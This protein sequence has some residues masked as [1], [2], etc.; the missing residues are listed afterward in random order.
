MQDF[1]R[2]IVLY[3]HA[4]KLISHILDSPHRMLS[5]KEKYSID[6]NSDLSQRD[7]EKYTEAVL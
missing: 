6:G 3:R 4:T 5:R 7:R 2:Q 1:Y